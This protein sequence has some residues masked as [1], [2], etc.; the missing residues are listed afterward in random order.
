MDLD[1]GKRVAIVTGASQGIGRAVAASLHAEGA[2]VVVCARDGDRLQASVDA[3]RGGSDNVVALAADVTE[4]ADLKRLRDRALDRFGRIDILVNNAGTSA[5]TAFLDL[6][7]ERLQID[8]DVKLF[9]AV[10][11][12]R[13]VLPSMIEARWGRIVNV[14]AIQG[15]HPE[16]GSMPTALSRAAGLAMTK[17]LSK[18]MAPHGVLVNA[19]CIGLVRSAQLDARRAS[20]DVDLDEHYDALSRSHGVPLGRVGLPEEVAAVV[21]FLCS[22]AASYVSG[23]AIN[24]DG[25]LSHVL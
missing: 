1:L 25:G 6:A 14:T 17:A 20:P 11:L 24:I 7:D 19:I 18:E 9:G 13:L 23:T 2:S 21:T 8:L 3:W 5:R 16:A 10:R 15:K 4:P 22:A 12:S